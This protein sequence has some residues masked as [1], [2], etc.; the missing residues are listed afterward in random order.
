MFIVFACFFIDFRIT[1]FVQKLL[2][3]SVALLNT[4]LSISVIPRATF[5]RSFFSLFVGYSLGWSRIHFNLF[6]ALNSQI[7]KM[8]RKMRIGEFLCWNVWYISNWLS[9]YRSI[10]SISH[11][12][13]HSIC[14]DCH[15]LTS[16]IP[17]AA[18]PFCHL[19]YRFFLH[20]R[21]KTRYFAFVLILHFSLKWNAFHAVNRSM[22]RCNKRMWWHT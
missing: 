15:I 3:E 8:L 11:S 12:K 10:V 6:H 5:V 7:L 14:H 22:I 16:Q 17:N 4:T 18:R 21:K 13:W 1:F 2:A 9:N 20:T 19:R